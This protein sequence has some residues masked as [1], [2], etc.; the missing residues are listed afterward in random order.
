MFNVPVTFLYDFEHVSDRMRP[1]I[2]EEFALAGAKHLVLSDTL[3]KMMLSHPGLEDTLLQEISG[4]GMS[5]CDAHAPFGPVLD[6]NCPFVEK[7]SIMLGRLKLVLEL[8]KY[9]NVDTITIHLGNNHFEPATTIAD[10]IHI[11]RMKESLAEL[12]PLAEKLGITICIENIW[13]SVNTP[14]VLNS[15]KAEF[16]T[17]ALGFCYDAGHANIMDNGRQ[18]ATGTAW[19][20]WQASGKPVPCWEPQA[21]E[22]MLPH[23]VNCHLHDNNGWKDEHKLPGQ[24]CVNWEKVI[25]LLKSAPRLKVIQSEVIP[26]ASGTHIRELV[27]KFNELSEIN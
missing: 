13:F 3:I 12:L 7:R 2:M 17:D 10:S 1:Y 15:I 22:K 8:C 21:L 18:Y 5:F 26:V 25:K 9:M 23:I 19:R 11:G 14:D 24:G 27:E 6:L 4:T 20:G 16:P